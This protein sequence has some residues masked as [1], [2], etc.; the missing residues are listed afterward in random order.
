MKYDIVS[1]P[2]YSLIEMKLSEGE[3]VIVEPGSMA[4][5]D[6]TIKPKTEMKGGFLQELKESLEVKVSFLIHTLPKVVQ[7]ISVLHRGIQ[8]T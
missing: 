3:S 6:T 2:S 7:V 4:W 8:E 5:M 1:A